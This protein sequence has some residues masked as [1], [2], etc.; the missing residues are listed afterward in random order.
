MFGQHCTMCWG[1]HYRRFTDCDWGELCDCEGHNCAEVQLTVRY[2]VAASTI[3]QSLGIPLIVGV[4]PTLILSEIDTANWQSWMCVM[5]CNNRIRP[6]WL[7]GTGVPTCPD[8]Q[9]W[10]CLQKYTGDR[11][12][13][14]AANV[15]N[16]TGGVKESSRIHR[17]FKHGTDGV[18]YP[19]TDIRAMGEDHDP[20]GTGHL[21]VRVRSFRAWELIVGRDD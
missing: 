4:H 3:A 14:E 16:S 12:C 19:G 9:W 20:A 15:R 2:A 10:T 7:G 13:R 18:W 21:T 5:H 17:I 6:I 8:H 11:L 1:L